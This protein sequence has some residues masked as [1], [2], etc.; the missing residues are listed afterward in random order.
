MRDIFRPIVSEE[1][2]DQS[3]QIP[4]KA[5]CCTGV[6]V[7]TLGSS[8]LHD[9]NRNSQ[10]HSQRVDELTLLP[11]LLSRLALQFL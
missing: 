3:E 10:I 8:F 2:F 1:S 11:V 5:K 7:W 4:F 6:S 9:Q